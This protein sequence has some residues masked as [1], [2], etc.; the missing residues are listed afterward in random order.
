MNQAKVIQK[1]NNIGRIE[2][3][4]LL[5]APKKGLVLGNQSKNKGSIKINTFYKQKLL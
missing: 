5:A 3:I 4:S 1:F 2:H